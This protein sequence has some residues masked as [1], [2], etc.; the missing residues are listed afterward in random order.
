MKAF[1]GSQSTGSAR[2][3]AILARINAVFSKAP[4]MGDSTLEK[5]IMIAQD[6]MASSPK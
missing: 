2:I 4:D 6:R 1:S 3:S 5:A